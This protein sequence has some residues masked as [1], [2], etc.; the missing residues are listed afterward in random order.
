[1]LLRAARLARLPGVRRAEACERFGLSIGMLR[2]AIRE[3]GAQARPRAWEIVL[4][5]LTDAG[6]RVSGDSLPRLAAVASYV[7]FVN[8]D[9]CTVEE[10][11]RI[12]DGLVAEGVLA[13]DGERWELL[14][15]FP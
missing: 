11:R 8:K 1:M 6:T 10:V 5:A 9:G 2:R 15:E 12:L 14:V 13:M 4:H 7:D 3:F